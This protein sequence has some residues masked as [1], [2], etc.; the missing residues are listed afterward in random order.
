MQSRVPLAFATRM[1]CW[2]LAS[3]STRTTTAFS[4]KLVLQVV[5]HWT[6][7]LP[8]VTPLQMQD[9]AFPFV[10]FHDIPVD[11]FLHHFEVL[12]IGCN[13]H[14]GSVNHMSRFC[15]ICKPAAGAICPRYPDN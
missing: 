15:M 7:L 12:L 8:V 10:E 3:W 9:F 1:G 2:L 5:G 14:N 13:M 6:V 11:G 4:D